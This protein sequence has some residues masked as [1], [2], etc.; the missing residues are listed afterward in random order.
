MRPHNGTLLCD[1]RVA[2]DIVCSTWCD[3]VSHVLNPEQVYH[4]ITCYHGRLWRQMFPQDYITRACLGKD[5]RDDRGVE[6]CAILAQG[7]I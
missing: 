7:V 1:A 4:S 2:D 6:G 5:D 3:P